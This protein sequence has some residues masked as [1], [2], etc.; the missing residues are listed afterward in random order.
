M[1]EL[2]N[3]NKP[4]EVSTVAKKTA[5]A[6]TEKIFTLWMTVET[7]PCEDPIGFLGMNDV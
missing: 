6:M 3:M 2:L 4:K 7:E 5:V 1:S